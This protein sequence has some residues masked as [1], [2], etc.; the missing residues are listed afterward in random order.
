MQRGTGALAAPGGERSPRVV[1]VGGGFGGLE[2]AKGLGKL[3]VEVTLLD[4]R[5]Y[6]LFQPLLYQV[7]TGGLSPADIAM[8]LR[9]ILRRQANTRVLMEEVTDIDPQRRLVVGA[10]A[11]YPYDT[12]IVAA[13]STLTYFGREAWRRHA[14]GLKSV[15]E[16]LE[17]RNRLL[18]AFEEAERESDPQRRRAW[19]SFVVVGGGPTGVELA[20]ALGEIARDTLRGDFRSIRPEEARIFLVELAPRVLPSFP[21]DLSEAAELSLI[22]LGVR[23]LT[24]VRVAEIDE[25]G[26]ELERNG[27][28]E[29]L[30]ARTVIWAAG[31]EAHPL[32]RVL[33]E[34]T[35][36]P[37]DRAGRVVVEP[38]CSLPGYPE[39]FVIGDLARCP[40]GR[41]GALPALAPVAMQQGRYVA[42]V[43]ASRLQN[44]CVRPF[45]FRDRGMLA[46]I[47]REHAVGCFGRLRVKG[48]LAWLLWLFVHL[49]YLIG[50]QNRVLVLIQWAFHYFSYHRG[51]RII[52]Q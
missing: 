10:R 11:A 1:I 14:P 17:I 27:R 37:L 24:G 49:A 41:G 38:D 46:T 20:G 15:E 31:V 30:C 22:R 50:F 3:P 42:H 43:I 19:M 44:R 16:A 40:D 2:A 36:A 35:G 5:N 39:I 7:A 4:R 12:L 45:R 33:H 29:R 34:R 48:R 13:G 52:T 9:R 47:G 25:E 23:P 6:F 21:E 26:V 28:R 51:A 8:P 18:R 32:A